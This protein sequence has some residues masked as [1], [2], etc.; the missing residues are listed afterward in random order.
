MY[1]VVEVALECNPTAS[2]SYGHVNSIQHVIQERDEPGSE[3]SLGVLWYNGPCESVSGRFCSSKEPETARGK[4]I[5]SE[6]SR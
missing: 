6:M 1:N 5:E 2:Q 4:S 3:V